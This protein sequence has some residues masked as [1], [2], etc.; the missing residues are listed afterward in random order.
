MSYIIDTSLGLVIAIVLLRWLDRV[1]NERNWTALKDSG[2]YAG[3]DAITHWAA[4]VIAWLIILSI[5]KVAIYIFMWAFSNPL[6]WAGG[7]LFAHFEDNIH[8]EL[9]VVMIL[10][11]GVLNVVYFWIADGYLRANKEHAAA[12][13]P[14]AFT[15]KREALVDEPSTEL[16]EK[17]QDYF[18]APWSALSEKTQAATTAPGEVHV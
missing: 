3:P 16:A 15:D 18:A 8:F 10:F 2:I 12:H 4:Q 6:A 11:P 5:A 14:D 17:K 1:A 13:E 7:L 9:V